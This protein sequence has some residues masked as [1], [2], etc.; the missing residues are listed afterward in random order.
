MTRVL[1]SVLWYKGIGLKKYPL[2]NKGWNE[3]CKSWY[4]EQ[5]NC[6]SRSGYSNFI[7]QSGS[8]FLQ[9]CKYCS[10]L[11]QF[12]M[13]HLYRTVL[14]LQSLNWNI[15]HWQ[16]YTDWRVA[17]PIVDKWKTQQYGWVL[18]KTSS[19]MSFLFYKWITPVSSMSSLCV[20]LI[21][22]FP[23]LNCQTGFVQAMEFWKNYGI[24]K[25]K[26]HIWKNYGIWAKRPYLWKKLWSFRFGRKKC[27][28]SFKKKCGKNTSVLRNLV[29]MFVASVIISLGLVLRTSRAI[30]LAYCLAEWIPA[31]QLTLFVP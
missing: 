7:S 5:N 15:V 16:L 8:S 12:T 31:R 2:Q 9:F 17:G 18:A 28:L 13:C 14:E 20:S 30:A 21:C 11:Q 27:V 24:L 22:N 3:Q 25:R 26:F 19:F 4:L 6:W 29:L 1:T 23:F 10:Q